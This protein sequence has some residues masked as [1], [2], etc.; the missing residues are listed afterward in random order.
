MPSTEKIVVLSNCT[1]LN[2]AQRIAK[3]LVELNLAACVNI[4]SAPMES[5]YRWEGEIETA[6]EFLLV[7]KTSRDRFD[8]VEQAIRELHSYEV[9]EI[10]AIA[11]EAGSKDYLAWLDENVK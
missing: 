2:E 10:I 5:I 4:G 6:K 9:P 3:A 8:A 11:I 1:S 7:A